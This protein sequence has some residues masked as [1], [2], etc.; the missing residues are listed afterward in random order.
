MVPGETIGELK[1]LDAGDGQQ[2]IGEGEAGGGAEVELEGVAAALHAGEIGGSQVVED[3]EV[4]FGGAA[5][6][7]GDAVVAPIGGE[8]VAISTF[9][10]FKKVVSF[11]SIEGVAALMT[12][13]TVIALKPFQIVGHGS[14]DDGVIAG[15]SLESVGAGGLADELVVTCSALDRGLLEEDGVVIPDDAISEVKFLDAM[16]W[17]ELVFNDSDP[18]ILNIKIN[19]LSPSFLIDLARCHIPEDDAITLSSFT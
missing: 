11:A 18:V 3:H 1:L 10:T 12:G 17:V 9:A 15:E 13:Q 19:V 16:K 14:T 2:L 4:G 6:T 7:L 5:I 8:Q